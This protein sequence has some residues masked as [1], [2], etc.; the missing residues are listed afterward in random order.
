MN[1]YIFGENWRSSI[2]EIKYNSETDATYLMFKIEKK[3]GKYNFKYVACKM[4]L[5]I[6]KTSNPD[7]RKEILFGIF[8]ITEKGVGRKDTKVNIKVIKELEN[9]IRYTVAQ[10]FADPAVFDALQG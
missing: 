9:F 1:G 6:T 4:E 7:I 10:H 8:V 2:L 3:D 5:Q